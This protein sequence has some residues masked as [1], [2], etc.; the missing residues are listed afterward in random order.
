LSIIVDA[1][2]ERDEDAEALL[3]TLTYTGWQRADGTPPSSGA[4]ID[5]HPE[6]A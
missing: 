4:V 1:P 2:L 6:V 5:G 3:A